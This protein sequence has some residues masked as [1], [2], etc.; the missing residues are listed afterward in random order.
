MGGLGLL[1]DILYNSAEQIDNGAYGRERIYSTLGGPT[2]GLISDVIKV[3]A[4]ALDGNASSNAKE[5]VATREVLQ[6][7]PILGGRRD[8][9]ESLVDS[10]A[11]E[12][13][14]SRNRSATSGVYSFGYK[15]GYDFN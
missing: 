11:G 2:V 9:R 10:I 1:G 6:R 7:I 13:S 14:K 4:G 15:Y 12:S 3:G 8:V 5:R